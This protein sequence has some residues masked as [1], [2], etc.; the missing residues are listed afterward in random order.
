MTRQLER[1]PKGLLTFVPGEFK[2][3]DEIVVNA[4]DQFTRTREKQER[5]ETVPVK[6]IKVNYSKETGEISV[7]NDGE[8]IPELHEKEK[9]YIP[10]LIFGNLLT[11]SNYDQTE[12]KHVGGKNGYGAL[13]ANIF[14]RQFTI[15]TV[16]EK[17]KLKFVQTFRD[18]MKTKEKPKIS[19]YSKKPYT[20]VSYIPDYARF[21]QTGLTDDMIKIIVKR[22][23]DMAAWTDNT[24]NVFLNGEKIESKNFEKYVDLYIGGKSET[25][26][27]YE[28]VN[29]RW[30][31]C[32]CLNPNVSFEQ[33]SFV[34]GIQT[35]KGGKHVDTVLNNIAKRVQKSS[36]E[37]QDYGEA[38]VYQGEHY[39]FH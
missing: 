1:W 2:I 5:G 32:A 7:W 29:D 27:A 31:V 10:E 28:K 19:K 13:L 23:Y 11:S 39:A 14:S 26:R 34:N 17:N 9:I 12:K 37:K 25:P 24:V 35:Y 3:F 6:N 22:A 8:G 33:V 16:D 38:S 21:K 4:L 30:E 18:N 36:Q 20:Q 15:E